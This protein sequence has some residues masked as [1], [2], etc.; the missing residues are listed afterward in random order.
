MHDHDRVPLVIST[1]VYIDGDSSS[2]SAQNVNAKEK[3]GETI[4]LVRLDDMVHEPVC[5]LKID[6]QGFEGKVVQGA[7][8]LITKQG[9]QHIL[10][11]L[12]PSGMRNAGTDPAKFLESLYD[13]GYTCTDLH[14]EQGVVWARDQ[15]A[16][17]VAMVEHLPPTYGFQTGIIWLN[18]VATTFMFAS[19]ISCI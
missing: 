18:S 17:K 5:L 9:V 8:D 7:H 12:W 19:G 6:V 14:R 4:K 13:L 3:S 11:E 15:L 1:Q 16:A 10:V 2:L